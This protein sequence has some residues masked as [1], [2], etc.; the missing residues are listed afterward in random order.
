MRQGNNL[1]ELSGRLCDSSAV[2]GRHDS[3]G[4]C[5]AR[6]LVGL[7]LAGESKVRV[8]KWVTPASRLRAKNGP[9][10]SRSQGP[11]TMPG[12]ES[13]GGRGIVSSA[14]VVK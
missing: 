1:V 7:S 12:R 8:S 2:D 11:G 9:R 3:L 14:P 10:E 4:P 13:K 5:K 6:L